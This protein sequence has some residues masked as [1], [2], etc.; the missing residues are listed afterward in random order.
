MRRETIFMLRGVPHSMKMIT[1]SFPRR[2][3][4]KKRYGFWIKSG[5]TGSILLHERLCCHIQEHFI[6]FAFSIFRY[7]SEVCCSNLWLAESSSVSV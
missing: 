2:R 1:F 6:S 7:A 5:M 4:I 3:G